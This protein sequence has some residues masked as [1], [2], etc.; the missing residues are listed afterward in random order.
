LYITY[1]RP[2]LE[3]GCVVWNNCTL[4]EGE[5]LEKVQ[6]A[7]ARVVS[8]AK[9][10]TSHSAL[11]NE[12]KWQ[13]LDIRRYN[14]CMALLFKMLKKEAPES[15]IELLPGRR[16]DQ[17]SYNIRNS[18]NLTIPKSGSTAHYK[19]FIPSVCREWNKLPED[20]KTCNS[21]E[22]FKEKL[23]GKKERPPPYYNTGE[24]KHQIAQCQMRVKNSNLNENLHRIG[25]APTP[26]CPCGNANESTRH[27]LL[28]C[29][30]YK[31]ARKMTID[32]IEYHSEVN[33]DLLL[34]GD[35]ERTLEEN[36]QI[37][38]HV[39]NYIRESERFQ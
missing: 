19:S 14:Q 9:R 28:E 37:F 12:T 6:L 2:I 39:Q 20:M 8:G 1:I 31:N 30:L 18:L 26:L 15:L 10:G 35:A 29:D 4:G 33:T 22:S 16:A 3:N 34:Y 13:R 23:R 25:L 32:K 36:I 7:A 24:R 5:A 38:K 21:T 27:Y 11:Y 17:T